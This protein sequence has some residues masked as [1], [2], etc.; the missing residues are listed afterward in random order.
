MVVAFDRTLFLQIKVI[1]MNW[2][3]LL[4]VLT[5]VCFTFV[6]LNILPKAAS[7]EETEADAVEQSFP[8]SL[9]ELSDGEALYEPLWY[10]VNEQLSL[11]EDDA[12]ALTLETFYEVDLGLLPDGYSRQFVTFV[13][14]TEWIELVLVAANQD[15]SDII[16]LSRAVSSD[17]GD[18][19]INTSKLE[20][21]TD[22]NHIYVWSQ[23]PYRAFESN[24]ELEWA[25]DD[26]YVVSHEY[27][28]PTERYYEEK[29]TLLKNK[30]IQGLILQW[31]NDSP[32]YPGFYAENFTLAAP[33]LRFAHQKALEAQKKKN[34][35]AA[36]SYLQYGLA[37]YDEA[38]YTFGYTEGTLSKTDIVGTEDSLYP[39]ARL[40]LSVYVGILNDYGYFLSLAGRNKEAKPILLNVVKLI[41]NRTV[42]Y[43]NLADVEWALGQK[44][45]AKIHYKQYMKLLGSKASKTAPKHVQER[46]KAK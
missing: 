6:S 5:V 36:L 35:K 37:Q 10:F 38:F 17:E 24:V 27:G 13:Y 25:G 21:W 15:A 45:T 11:S 22:A 40:S 12:S 18:M 2:K 16:L 3:K 46:I 29:A 32:F 19:F 42:A 23:A 8:I 9:A 39:E 44:S 1:L 7:A 33:V 34:L 28:D 4:I 43:L 31:E 20:F 14:N 30:D 26:L 41:P